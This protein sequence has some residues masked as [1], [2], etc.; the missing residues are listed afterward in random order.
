MSEQTKTDIP[1]QNSD[2]PSRWVWRCTEESLKNSQVS[3]LSVLETVFVLGLYYFLVQHFQHHWWLLLTAFA[4]P[5]I[6][7]RSEASVALGV[8]MLRSYKERG[9]GDVSKLEKII[10]TVLSVIVSFLVAYWLAHLVLLDYQGWALFW[11][12]ALIGASAVAFAFVVAVVFVGAFVGAFAVAFAV[13]VAV[14]DTGADTSAFG[15]LIKVASGIVFYPSFVFGIWLRSLIIR[16]IAT[17]RYPIRG[18][19]QLPVNWHR[20][21]WCMDFTYPPEL[22]PDAKTV[23][24]WFS[25][26][27]LFEVLSDP[28]TDIGDYFL[29]LAFACFWYFSALLW[30]WSLKATLWVW[31]PLAL[32]LKQPFQT[33]NL[34]QMRRVVVTIVSGWWKWLIMPVVIVVPWLLS[35]F[36][37][38]IDRLVD[39][40]LPEQRAKLFHELVNYAVP[41]PLSLRYATIWLVCILSIVIWFKA[42]GMKTLF[43]MMIGD[44]TYVNQIENDAQYAQQKQDFQLRAESIARWHT[45]RIASF[46]LLG[47]SYILYLA[48][49]WYPDQASRFIADWLITYL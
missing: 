36:Y 16:V 23:D 2:S 43:P 46:I 11:C 28:N 33:D 8:R 37:P 29:S 13:A 10:I 7:L 1:P 34:Y 44:E 19:K 24:E 6:L 39:I 18:I 41:E 32:V 47:Y 21:S 38:K 27:G 22:L 14:V 35:V 5:I 40:L 17:L 9:E 26:G 42:N 30:R 12:S 25:V 49:L 4:A 31:W 45:G 15:K 48:N 20:I 3:I